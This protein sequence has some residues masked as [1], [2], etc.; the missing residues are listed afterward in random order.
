MLST[1]E[2]SGNIAA[3]EVKIPLD[4]DP[5]SLGCIVL[6]GRIWRTKVLLELW[7]DEATS[8]S[9]LRYCEHC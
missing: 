1:H 4:P 9:Y 7:I 2:P 6:F 3:L 8:N 5:F